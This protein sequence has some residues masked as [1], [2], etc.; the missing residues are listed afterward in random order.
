MVRGRLW[1]ASNPDLSEAERQR[2]VDAL[3]AARRAVREAKDD[4]EAMKRARADVQA[5]K[6]ALGERGPVWWRDGAPDYNRKMARNTPYA[7]WAAEQ[8]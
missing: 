2:H 6:V 7:E 4:P 5:A 1:R 3:M 8:A